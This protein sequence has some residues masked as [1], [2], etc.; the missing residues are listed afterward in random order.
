MWINDRRGDSHA[1]EQTPGRGIVPPAGRRVPGEA[2]M[3][4]VRIPSNRPLWG[5][6]ESDRSTLLITRCPARTSHIR[7]G[8][9]RRLLGVPELDAF[10]A[11]I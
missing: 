4:R 5:G 7:A 1:E 8:T 9:A 11:A 6:I 3:C 10:G 2:G